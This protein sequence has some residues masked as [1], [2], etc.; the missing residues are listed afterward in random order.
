M[1]EI[2]M[3][4]TI[5]R[6]IFFQKPDFIPVSYVINPSYYFA[7]DLDDIFDLQER[8]P[9]L[10]PNFVRPKDNAAFLETYKNSLGGVMRADKPFV[11][12]FGC[13]WETAFEGMTG[14]VT[15]HPLD[16]PSKFASYQCPDPEICKGIGPMDWAKAREQIAAAKAAGLFTAGGLRH[17]HT[18][19]QLTDLCGY[20]NF[21]YY[22]MDEEPI[23]E[24]LIQGVNDFNCAIIQKYIDMDVDMITIPEDL[25]MQHGPMITLEHFRQYIKPSYQ[26]MMKMVRDAGKIVHMHSDGDIRDLVDDI[27]EGG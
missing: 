1:P 18:F 9:Q 12:D 25:G 23:L 19:L 10:F 5:L 4:E 16:D 11:D 13:T 6:S 3:R 24:P 20:Q 26:R 15:K 7:N 21:I 14:T 27:I 17:G 8:H 22:M 2:N